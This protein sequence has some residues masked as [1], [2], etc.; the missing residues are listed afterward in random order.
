MV[1]A[2]IGGC[3]LFGASDPAQAPPAVDGSDAGGDGAGNQAVGGPA[4]DF[5]LSIDPV[6]APLAVVPGASATLKLT[7]KRGKA[8]VDPVVITVTGL[9]D[10]I[11]AAPL[12]I[13]TGESGD[14][15]I[16]AP[17][18]APQGAVMGV[19]EAVS[20]T[21]KAT[22]PLSA[23]VRGKPGDVDTTYAGGTGTVNGLFGTGNDGR[24]VD[25]LLAP[26]D[27]VYVVGRC[28]G[29]TSHACVVHVAA[30]GTPDKA[31]GTAGLAEL[32]F[33]DPHAAAL[34]PDGKLIVVG[35]FSPAYT[36]MG[37]LDATGKPD[38]AFGDNSVGP[39]TIQFS[40]GGL[41]GQAHGA[42]GV[43]LRA[44]GDVFV[45]WDNFD[46]GPGV[47]KNAISHFGPNGLVRTTFGANGAA[48]SGFGLTTAVAV[49]NDPADPSHGNFLL[50]WENT[51]GTSGTGTASY[52][53]VTG[54]T[55]AVD[56]AFGAGIKSISI[57]GIRRPDTGQIGLVQLADRSVITAFQGDSG[58]Y[59]YKVAPTFDGDATFGAVGLAGPYV[60][61]GSAS[62]IAVQPDG[63][64]LIA[65][66]HEGGHEVMRLTDKG[67]LD[68]TFGQTGHATTLVGTNSAANKVVVQKTGRILVAGSRLA[69]GFDG[70]IVS[71]WP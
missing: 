18:A 41:S 62:G 52:L 68:T 63:A 20:G 22:T 7:I 48:R 13:A 40:T 10:G 24:V 54:D 15:V 71:F 30:D 17:A 69:P 38:T 36:V 56:P 12:T 32:T 55:N 60:I 4:A 46:T 9:R 39:G 6:A 43:A 37:R 19:I 53:Q 42:Y 50:F 66:N 25:M 45:T 34:Q 58:L 49:R 11:A 51:G 64:V 31:Y 61:N 70:A 21:V 16:S 67:A 23:L 14:L 5:A 33:Q 29:L 35:G 3:G 2:L 65:L 57:A 8:L 28:P 47:Y 1:T 27:S 59:A 44:D 26:D